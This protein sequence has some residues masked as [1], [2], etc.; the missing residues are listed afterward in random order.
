MRKPLSILFFFF[1]ISSQFSFSQEWK[2]MKDYQ[3]TTGNT[4]LENGCWLKKDR[5]RNTETWKYANKFNMTLTDGNL[6]YKTIS[7]IRDFYFWL[8]GEFKKQE[9][10]INTVGVVAIVADQLS[11]FDNW[12]IRK[13]IVRNKEVIWFGNE[14]SNKVL[15]YA[16]PIFQ[17]MYNSKNILKGEKARE[18]DLEYMKK[19]QCQI[20]EPLYNRLS[21][22]A[23]KKL[24]RIAKGK[25]IFNLGIKN[26][27]KFKGDILDCN[28]RTEHAFL[29]VQTYYLKK[30]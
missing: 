3:K 14:G 7:Q 1:L 12:F 19:E 5:K 18:W 25:G 11:N 9:H 27:L 8:D 6:K 20:V 30:M 23:I 4:V 26:E 24:K 16:F 15:A 22:K 10:E 13:I 17:E 2:N 21:A 29:K 28:S